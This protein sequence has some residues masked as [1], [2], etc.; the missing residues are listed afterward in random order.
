MTDIVAEL[1]GYLADFSRAWASRDILQRA[2]DE[3]VALRDCYRREVLKSEELYRRSDAVRAEALE[4]AARVCDRL[5]SAGSEVRRSD[6][7]ACAAAIRALK[8]KA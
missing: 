4:E 2:R 6:A 5:W 7:Y 1:D 8:D 3:I